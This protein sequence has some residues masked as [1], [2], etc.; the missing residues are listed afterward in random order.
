MRDTAFCETQK[1]Y[2]SCDRR[3]FDYATSGTLAG[4]CTAGGGITEVISPARTARRASRK[5]LTAEALRTAN[6][7]RSSEKTR[8]FAVKLSRLSGKNL[9]YQIQ[10]RA[11]E[12]REDPGN[13]KRSIAQAYAAGR[14]AYLR[15]RVSWRLYLAGIF[16]AIAIWRYLRV[17]WQEAILPIALALMLLMNWFAFRGGKTTS[18]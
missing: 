11:V 4:A 3:Y 13:A 12:N 10:D 5:N 17:G 2:I 9:F 7:L 15:R 14:E 1:P 18:P 16:A 8:E 6:S